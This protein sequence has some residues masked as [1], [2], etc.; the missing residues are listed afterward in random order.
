MPKILV[1]YTY[2]KKNDKYSLL[3]NNEYVFADMP[4]AEMELGQDVDEDILI[5]PIN[6]RYTV[7][8]KEEYLKVHKEFKLSLLEDGIHLKE[9]PNGKISVY[10]PKDTPVDKLCIQNNQL[11]LEDTPTPEE[12]SEIQDKGD[13]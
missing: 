13:A 7:V 3:V 8:D 12:I 2:N 9:D 5:V 10:L 4:I 6:G 1:N 11:V